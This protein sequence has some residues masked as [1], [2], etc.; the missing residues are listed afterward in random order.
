MKIF[1]VKHLRDAIRYLPDD[2][3][4]LVQMDANGCGGY[5]DIQ[6]VEIKGSSDSPCRKAYVRV[7]IENLP[8][9]RSP[10]QVIQTR[11]E[12]REYWGE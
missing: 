7:L 11:K 4:I 9:Y 8:G 6:V 3:D 5:I 12:D 1:K 2:A 10:T